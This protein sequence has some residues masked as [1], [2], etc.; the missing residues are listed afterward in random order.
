MVRLKGKIING[1]INNYKLLDHLADGGNGMVWKAELNDRYYAIKFLKKEEMEDKKKIQ[2]FNQ[3]INF[4]SK[5]NH[6]NVVRIFDSGEFDG[7]LFYVM[8]LY[9]ET[10]RDVI[11]KDITITKIFN[12]IFQICD[13]IRFIH[14]LGAIHRDIKPENILLDN[15]KLV[16]ADLGIAHFKNLDITKEGELL[17]N[18]SYAAPEQKIKGLSKEITKS[19]DIYALGC[20]INELFTKE[21]P[22]GTNFIKIADKYPWL[23]K[24]DDIVDQCMRQN[25]MERPNIDEILLEIKLL[26]GKSEKSIQK[27]KGMLKNDCELQ[28]IHIKPT[29]LKELLNVCAEDILISKYIFENV[30]GEDLNKYNHNYNCHIHYKIDEELQRKYFNELLKQECETKFN[31]ESHI[32]KKDSYYKSLDLNLKTDKKLY[33]RFFAIIDQYGEVDGGILKLFASCCDYHCE[34]ILKYTASIIKEVDDLLDAPILY[35]VMK[36]KNVINDDIEIERHLLINWE[37]TI[38]DNSLTEIRG[39]TLDLKDDKVINVLDHFKEKYNIVYRKRNGRYSVIFKDLNSY[40]K[41]KEYAISLSKP[42]YTFAGDV[43]DIIRI[44]RE[45]DGIVELN[46]LDSFDVTNVLAKVLG[47]RTDY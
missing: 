6:D 28:G 37:E 26:K 2:R 46:N 33:D 42:Y 15:E 12:Y 36:L 30:N 13:G 5:N 1:K 4:L 43:L 20:I 21:N 38:N 16:I 19:V 25:P 32:Y 24:M 39:L 27:I 47:L 9:D 31:Y 11:N 35:I 41:F 44:Q 14:S 10:L 7:K 23:N 45:Y 3:E 40:Y 22:S 17:A 18:R 8:P 29:D 34:E